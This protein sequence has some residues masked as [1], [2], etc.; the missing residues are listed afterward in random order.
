MLWFRAF[1]PARK[2]LEFPTPSLKQVPGPSPC[3]GDAPVGLTNQDHH[4]NEDN[5]NQHHTQRSQELLYTMTFLF[6]PMGAGAWWRREQEMWAG[7]FQPP[8]AL[9]LLDPWLILQPTGLG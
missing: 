9:F 5:D 1:H 7:S 8:F 6:H 3:H 2:T 4:Q